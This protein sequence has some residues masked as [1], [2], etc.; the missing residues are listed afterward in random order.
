MNYLDKRMNG[1]LKNYQTIQL[2]NHSFLVLYL[3]IQDHKDEN[4][5]LYLI[6]KLSTQTLPTTILCM[7]TQCA[8]A[9]HH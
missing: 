6:T 4:I 9:C 5:E 3:I 1:A 2:T 8:T 7:P